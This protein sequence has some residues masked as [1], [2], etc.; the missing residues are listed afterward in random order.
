MFILFHGFRFEYLENDHQLYVTSKYDNI[1]QELIENEIANISVNEY[2]RIYIKTTNYMETNH[3]KAMFESI[4]E[5]PKRI[6]YIVSSLIY[7]NCDECQFKW[8]HSFRKL[9]Q[10]KI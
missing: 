9:S 10:M 6:K 5:R 7:C 1:K 4:K 2:Q 8:S 3:V